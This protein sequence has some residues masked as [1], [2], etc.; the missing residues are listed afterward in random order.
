MVLYQEKKG[1]TLSSAFT[2][3]EK[4]IQEVVGD[5]GTVLYE[6]EK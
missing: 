4:S 5:N 6:A 1:T 2:D 3:E